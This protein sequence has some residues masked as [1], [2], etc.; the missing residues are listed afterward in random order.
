MTNP[1]S[2]VLFTAILPQFVDPHGSAPQLQLVV[3]GGNPPRH[4]VLL[5]DSIWALAAGSARA[6]F[7][8]RPER[9]ATVGGVGGLVTIGLGVRLAL[10]GR[11]D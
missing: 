4:R 6:W 11:H 9:L 3:L 1:K 2:I 8:K 7:G 5:S 10:T